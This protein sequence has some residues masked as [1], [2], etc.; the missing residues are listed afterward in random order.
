MQTRGSPTSRA[1]RRASSRSASARFAAR[2]KGTLS[3][4]CTARGRLAA[5]RADLARAVGEEPCEQTSLAIEVAGRE[6]LPVAFDLDVVPLL[7]KADVLDAESE[8]V[9]PEVGHVVIRML[10]AEDRMRD[11]RALA[12]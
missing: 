5:E 7:R 4:S 9:R 8:L 11:R 10:L 2:S 12:G 3:T 6:A 1:G